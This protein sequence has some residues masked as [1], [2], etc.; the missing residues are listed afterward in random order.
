[1]MTFPIFSF[2]CFKVFVIAFF[3]FIMIMS[4][5]AKTRQPILIKLLSDFSHYKMRKYQRYYLGLRLKRFLMSLRF[6]CFRIWNLFYNKFMCFPYFKPQS[7]E[8][9]AR[10]AQSLRWWT[11]AQAITVHFPAANFFFFLIC[12]L[13]HSY[14][15]VRF[16][17]TII[18]IKTAFSSQTI[19]L[20]QNTVNFPLCTFFFSAAYTHVPN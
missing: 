8:A 7:R 19:E 1:M 11:S 6:N 17:L 14:D 10:V 20:V 13:P 4:V 18:R 12:V 2:I 16:N 9:R 15:E 5:F 3:T